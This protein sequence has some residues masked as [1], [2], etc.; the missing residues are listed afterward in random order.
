[1]TKGY[2][3][4]AWRNLVKNKFYT[5]I[6]ISGLTIGLTVGILV[7][8]W[9]QNELSY[10]S[11]HHNAPNI[12]KV[13]SNLGKGTS[14]QIWP[15]SHAPIAI[16]ARQDIPEIKNAVRIKS[17]HDFT[18][19]TYGEK[20]FIERKAA[21]V[22]PSFFTVFDF[23][24]LK[25]SVRTPFN[26]DYSVILT[27]AAAKR[28]FNDDDPI[29]KV[30]VA[31]SKHNF[32]VVGIVEDFPGNSS[33]RY[34]MLFPLSLYANVYREQNDGRF[35]DQDWGTFTYDTFLQL[36]PGIS[37]NTVEDKLSSVLRTHYKDIGIKKPYSL[38]HLTNL[39]LYKI[40]GSDGQIQMVRI[41]IIVGILILAIACINY[42]NLSTARSILR[43]KE[44]SVRKIIGAGKGQLF[45]Q[46]FIETTVVF[47]ISSTL[48]LV[49]TELMMPVFNEVSG[50]NIHFDIIDPKIWGL[51]GITILF[52][53]I[54]SSIY[55]SWLLASMD[56]ITALKGKVIA[57][58]SSVFLR[59]VLVTV[60][61]IFS[62]S[63]IAGTLI[64]DRQVSFLH[65]KE[66]G[67][68]KEQVFTLQSRNIEPYGEVVKA[69]ISKQHGI[70]GVT[71]ANDELINIGTT[72]GKTDWEGKDPDQ[73]FF[74]HPLEIDKD[75]L[76]VFKIK[77]IVGQGFNGLA[78]DSA[79]Y[80]LNET[81]VK[82]AGILNPIGKRFTL[83]GDEGT[84][85]G[86]VK[87]FHFASLK[88]KIAPAIFRYRPKNS[89]M[90]VK[91]TGKDVDQAVAAVA[92][93]WKRYN[94]GFPYEYSFLDEDYNN[95]YQSENR[96][97]IIFNYF[98]II[99]VLISCMGLLGLTAFTAQVKTKE[100]GIRK[101]LGASILNIVQL[102][103]ADFMRPVFVAIVI[104][105]PP[106]WYVLYNWLQ[107]YAYRVEM[108][109][110]FFALAAMA[111]ISIALITIG[112]QSIKAAIMNPVKSIRTE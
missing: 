63:L 103:A 11:F 87:D 70:V 1:M 112:F 23:K 106:A 64:I 101:V 30:L 58:L 35:I 75:F 95:L 44:I 31:D 53:L 42:V 8:I 32:T 10:D 14:R 79:H 22:D 92:Q 9:V 81:A 5:A 21:Y 4:A 29:G 55:P 45:I 74:I 28:Y 43:A 50:K 65:K 102:L 85:I 69:E 83:E 47:I 78:T 66:L 49:L 77:V 105:I 38:Q 68:D 98:S 61:F 72:T 111:A 3:K 88:Q 89:Q 33:I 91:T 13:L 60:Q 84:I 52:T 37:T 56:P 48:A 82:E 41:F 24:L 86:V 67:Y 36:S 54:L 80:I 15:N 19:F 109:W 104:G 108:R 96:I 93:T 20:K 6:T 76:S 12:Y 62:V 2:L 90:Y 40:D 97:G 99:S 57:K 16:F 59:K 107:G 71:Y 18:L 25:G 73:A 26:G 110:W 34:D 27:A 7:F 17:N 39:H 46:F 100:I 94:A 51:V